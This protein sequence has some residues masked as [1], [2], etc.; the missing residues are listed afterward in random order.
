MKKCLITVLL[1]LLLPVSA[2]A[3]SVPE[4]LQQA[5]PRDAERLLPEEVN[6]GDLSFPEG[7]KKIIGDAA[8]AGRKLFREQLQGN[9]KILLVVLLC[10]A[11]EAMQKGVGKE[12]GVH[13]LTIAGTLSVLLLTVGN[14]HSMLQLGMETVHS[15]NDFS[16]I[17]LPALAGATAA[18]GAIGTA[19]MQQVTTV[20]LANGLLRLI[21]G[22]LLPAV[23]LY[24]G[25]LAAASMLPQSR[26]FTLAEYWKKGITW[27]L[28]ITLLAFTVY[29]SVVRVI[30][31][32]VDS[33]AV[34]V[35]K[36][37]IA[38]TIPVVGSILSET[39]ETVLAGAGM[40]K[41]T[42]GIFGMLAVLAICMLPFLKLGLQY[43][44]YKGTAALSAVMGSAE[45]CKLIDGLGSA[46]GL[47]LGMTGACAVLLL[48]S[49]LS[50]ISVV[51]P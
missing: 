50:S 5:L 18:A 2:Q 51:V 8:E 21:D 42:I 49:I 16:K 6:T 32:S 39:A 47:I 28:S 44:L 9:V 33:N 3:V 35:T 38:G 30:S 43:L 48:V 45:L 23:S 27:V 24:I 12:M 13:S 25:V 31:G 17:L 40:L 41:N 36:A 20:L 34:K 46:F 14:I 37:A 7:V 26:L 11:L 4:D 29:L 1:L 19:S 10:G 15:M 22:L